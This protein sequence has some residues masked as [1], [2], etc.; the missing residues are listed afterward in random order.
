[1]GTFIDDLAI[2]SEGRHDHRVT[3]CG[4]VDVL[5]SERT[6]LGDAVREFGDNWMGRVIGISQPEGTITAEIQ[7]G[8]VH[9]AN[10]ADVERKL[11]AYVHVVAIRTV[12]RDHVED[13]SCEK[14]YC[15]HS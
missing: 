5:I 12:R 8:P 7:Y 14:K 9:G 3:W 11:S 10:R 1:M 13:G 4:E 6:T 2:P 15:N